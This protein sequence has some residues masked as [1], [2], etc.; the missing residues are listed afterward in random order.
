MIIQEISV[1]EDTL[2]KLK[3]LIGEDRNGSVTVTLGFSELAALHAA[4]LNSKIYLDA[5]ISGKMAENIDLYA[6]VGADY[7][8]EA[9]VLIYHLLRKIKVMD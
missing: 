1:L 9:D 8:S 3:N 6:E 5:A 4:V 2:R 7:V